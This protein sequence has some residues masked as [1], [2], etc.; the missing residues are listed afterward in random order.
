MDQL[1]SLVGAI[2]LIVSY[3]ALVNG[4]TTAKDKDYLWCNF[5][6]STLMLVAALMDRVIGFI[7]V[8]AVWLVLTAISLKKTYAKAHSSEVN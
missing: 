5:I 1:L 8:N 2:V 7:L 4:Y 6:A 3:G